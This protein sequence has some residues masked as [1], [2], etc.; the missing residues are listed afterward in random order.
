MIVDNISGIVTNIRI[1]YQ[2]CNKS[3]LYTVSSTDTVIRTSR[4]GR[5]H[6]DS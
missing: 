4:I 5:L 3:I 1:T 2:E 6:Y